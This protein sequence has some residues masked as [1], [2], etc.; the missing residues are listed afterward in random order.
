MLSFDHYIKI[1]ESAMADKLAGHGL[2]GGVGMGASV[3]GDVAQ[4]GKALAIALGEH[5]S[6]TISFLR[7]LNDP[8]ING[9][10]DEMSAGELNRV[11]NIFHKASG[12][13]GEDDVI[14]PNAAD[15][16]SGDLP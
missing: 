3:A 4:M 8:R 12:L 6:R 5:K 13:G 16:Q 10:L 2:T 15:S 14:A 9:V 1:R 7:A 11:K